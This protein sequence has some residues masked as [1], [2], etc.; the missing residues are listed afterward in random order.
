MSVLCCA[1]A[2][3]SARTVAMLREPESASAG[4]NPGR[5]KVRKK[6]TPAMKLEKWIY[7]HNAMRLLFTPIQRMR[8][9]AIIATPHHW[10]D[11]PAEILVAPA[12]AFVPSDNQEQDHHALVKVGASADR[13]FHGLPVSS[14]V[15]PCDLGNGR[16]KERTMVS[17][18]SV[19]DMYRHMLRTIYIY[20]ITRVS[21]VS[22]HS[23]H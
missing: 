23:P 19:S 12:I 18:R 8:H 13:R 1:V 20:I 16:Y 15:P 3:G 7:L 14:Y 10:A 17:H 5:G 21:V 4:E 9:G 6:S 2:S 11:M 22:D